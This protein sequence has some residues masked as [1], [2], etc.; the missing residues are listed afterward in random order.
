MIVDASRDLERE[1]PSQILEVGVDISPLSRYGHRQHV[2]FVL[3]SSNDMHPVAV[4][5][6][7]HFPVSTICFAVHS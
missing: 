5:M 7:F 6:G 3:S 1:V 4:A 2:S